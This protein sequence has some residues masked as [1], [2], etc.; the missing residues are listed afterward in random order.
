MPGA[1]A[2]DSGSSFLLLAREFMRGKGGHLSRGKIS[3]AING[4]IG[5]LRCGS[6]IL[7]SLPL[8][9]YLSDRERE[10]DSPLQSCALAIEVVCV[11]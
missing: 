7:L 2:I 3:V 1:E 9:S 4:R 8:V 6:Y 11:A 5:G 10:R